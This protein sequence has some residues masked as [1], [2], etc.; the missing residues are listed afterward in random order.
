MR[1][2]QKVY[3]APTLAIPY[4]ALDGLNRSARPCAHLA[5][6]HTFDVTNDPKHGTKW[7]LA[8]EYL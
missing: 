1:R 6:N 2:R 8:R 4:C 3:T 5:L 7:L